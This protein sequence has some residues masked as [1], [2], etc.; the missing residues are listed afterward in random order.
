MPANKFP[1]RGLLKALG[2]AAVRLQL[3]FLILLHNF[4][5]YLVLTPSVAQALFLVLRY[6]GPVRRC[7]RLDSKYLALKP[8]SSKALSL[9]ARRS[10]TVKRESGSHTNP[11]R[12]GMRIGFAS[13]IEPPVER[14]ELQYTCVLA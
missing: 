5:V 8:A 10:R 7:S 2:S 14:L 12:R 3:H 6:E 11:R 1:R 4:L 9:P 13:R